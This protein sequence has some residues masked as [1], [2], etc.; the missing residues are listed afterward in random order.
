[1]YSGIQSYSFPSSHLPVP[2]H[3]PQH[4]LLLMLCLLPSLP[5]LL[6]SP[7]ALPVLLFASSLNPV[8]AAPVVGMGPPTGAWENYQWS[9]LK[10]KI[11]LFPPVASVRGRP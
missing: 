11:I 10:E 8:S 3:S 4:L 2:S 6:P 5:P 9:N 7:L 1:M